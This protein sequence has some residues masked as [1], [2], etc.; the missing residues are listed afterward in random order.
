MNLRR[1][2]AAF[3]LARGWLDEDRG[4]AREYRR[5][6]AAGACSTCIDRRWLP[7]LQCPQCGRS[8]N[9]FKEAA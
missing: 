7:E 5:L 4:L 2:T 8:D 1:M 9:P 6:I 3:S